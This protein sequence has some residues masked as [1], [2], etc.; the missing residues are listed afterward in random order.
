MIW[1]FS[2]LADHHA[3]S[4]PPWTAAASSGPQTSPRRPP[5]ALAAT[6]FDQHSRKSDCVPA[7][8]L[9][10]TADDI[11]R[12]GRKRKGARA[13]VLW[14]ESERR[15]DER[16]EIGEERERTCYFLKDNTVTFLR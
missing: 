16:R 9:P 2:T 15:R 4:R 13:K 10:N 3:S 14:P 1:P 5:S 12:G 8:S 6:P 7:R 11:N